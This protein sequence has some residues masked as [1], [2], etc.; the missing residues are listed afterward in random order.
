MPAAYPGANP[1]TLEFGFLNNMLVGRVGAFPSTASIFSGGNSWSPYTYVG[2]N[3]N[4]AKG[5]VGSILWTNTVQAPAGNV[6]ITQGPADPTANGGAGVFTEGYQQT[7]QWVGYSMATGQK[8]WGP[9]ASQTAF[10]YYGTPAVPYVQ[11][12]AAYGKLYSSGLGG[13]LYCYDLTTGHIVF[14]YGNGGEGNTTR[15]GFANAYGKY[16]TFINAI[17]NGIV[18]WLLLSTLSTHHSTKVH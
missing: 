2:I 1:V 7:M 8:L 5:A 12:C 14:T 18:Y 16:P 6:T 13:I 17:G 3:L 4:P 11:G 10:D 9:T 15:A